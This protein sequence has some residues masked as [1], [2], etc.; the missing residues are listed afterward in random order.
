MR[1]VVPL[2]LALALAA[3]GDDEATPGDP[4]DAGADVEFSGVAYPIGEAGFV[5]A[6]G[7]DAIFVDVP[8]SEAEKID[9]GEAISVQGVVARQD[10]GT[11]IQI[12]SQLDGTRQSAAPVVAEALALAPVGRGEPYIDEASVSGEG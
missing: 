12:Q 4:G 9:S 2:L 6:D 11:A 5:L 7:E 3:C 8:P 1:I 10:G